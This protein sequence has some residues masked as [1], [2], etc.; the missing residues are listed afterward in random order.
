MASV[1]R[2]LRHTELLDEHPTRVAY[3][4]RCEARP[5]FVKALTAQLGDLGG[6]SARS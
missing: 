6:A 2:V 1:L 4:P 5:A 3:K